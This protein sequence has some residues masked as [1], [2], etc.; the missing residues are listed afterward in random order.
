MKKQLKKLYNKKYY[1]IKNIRKFNL[2]QI[3]KHLNDLNNLLFLV[4]EENQFFKYK[5]KQYHYLIV[6]IYMRIKVL[7]N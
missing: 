4:D 1:I 7:E 5:N 2:K 3:E 6:I